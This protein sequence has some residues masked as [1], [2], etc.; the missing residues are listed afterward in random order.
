VDLRDPSVADPGSGS[1]GF[2][3]DNDATGSTDTPVTSALFSNVSSLGPLVTPE[4]VINPN[5]K[6]AMH[7]R[8][9]TAIQIY[10]TLSGGWPTGLFIDG[11]AAQAN[12]T[13]GD[14][15][16]M[17]VFLAGNK[18]SF[19]ERFDSTYFPDAALKNQRLETNDS[20]Q[21]TDPFNLDLP[22]LLPM[23]GSPVLTASSWYV[24]IPS[25]V[26]NIQNNREIALIYPNPF[27]ESATLT[28][29]LDASSVISA[30][31]YNVTGMMVQTIVNEKRS[32]GRQQFTIQIANKGV[33]FVHVNVN[34][35]T[36]VLKI[37][38]R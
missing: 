19:P 34:N 24:G 1:N 31:V 26:D 18:T 29:D 20:L 35:N 10:N 23:E 27:S 8:R 17:N 6:R 11:T 14:L 3:S 36:Q 2:E 28:V 32:A 5:F 33:Y 25:A 15:K 16:V 37:V 4:T 22:N 9:N 30:K 12:A 13:N 21:L 38:N 7:L